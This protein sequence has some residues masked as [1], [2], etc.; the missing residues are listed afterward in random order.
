MDQLPRGQFMSFFQPGQLLFVGSPTFS[1]GGPVS[2]TGLA[3]FKL[4]VPTRLIAK[5]GSDPFGE[6]VCS[7]VQKVDPRLA[8][9]IVIDAQAPTSYTVIVNPPGVDRI[10]LHCPGAND[11][12]GA[13][14]VD[15]SLVAQA[16]LFHFGYPPLMRRMYTDEGFELAEVFR[17][18]K[19]SGATTSLDMAFPDPTSPSGQAG[20]RT[21]LT[22]ALPFVDLFMPSIEELLFMIERETYE[23]LSRTA[24]GGDILASVT[25]ELLARL[26]AEMIALGA[27]IVVFKL[28]SRGLYL[29]TAG[30][31]ALSQIGRAA[32]ADLIGWANQE[33]WAPCFRVSVVG[34]TGSGDATISGFL[35]AFL[36][37]FSPVQA[38][39]AAV[40]VGACNVEAADALSGLRAWDETLSRVAAGWERLPLTLT[41]P[42]WTWS[43]ADRLWIGPA[44]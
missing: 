3:L 21:I 43:E 42:G 14:D 28:G 31:K 11:T 27:K 33:I 5:V 23:Q 18:A 25:P 24:P 44:G 35:S 1:T 39:T 9:G 26:S 19:A 41:S 38:V 36:R 7:L 20:W 32:P 37:D 34:T 10:F 4:G 15:E 40:A 30:M 13:A 2:N 8:Q 6:I 12:F 17:R 16:G 29:R 22:R